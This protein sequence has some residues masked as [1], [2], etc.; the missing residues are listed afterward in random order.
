MSGMPTVTYDRFMA[1][2]DNDLPYVE[3]HT[4]GSTGSPK[5]IRL[6][7]DDMTASAKATNRYFGISSDSILATPLSAGYIAGKMMAIRA[8]VA[9]AGFIP[10]KVSNNFTL[11]SQAVDLLAVV[12]SQTDCLLANPGYACAI[13]NVLVGGAPL[14]ASRARA[15]VDAGYAVYESYGMTETCSHI[16]LRRVGQP[17]FEAMPGITFDVDSRGCLVAHVPHLSIGQVV[18]NDMVRLEGEQA[19]EWLGR[20]DNVINSGGIKIHP[21]QLEGQIRALGITQPF[22]I[23]AHTDRKWGQ[24]PAM[25]LCGSEEDA[26]TAATLL[27]SKID[28]RM[29]PRTIVAVERLPLAQNGKIKRLPLSALKI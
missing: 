23:V 13:K 15:L 28:R 19:F 18:T 21:E 10:L 26:V 6:S 7:K 16:A 3:A 4:S 11:P 29:M 17:C 2:F 1:E 9:G 5:V 27:Q 8:K 25:V 20:Y 24:V 14:D 22:Y 12:P